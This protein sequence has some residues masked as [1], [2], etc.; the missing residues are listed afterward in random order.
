MHRSVRAALAGLLLPLALDAAAANLLVNPGNEETLVAGEIPGWTEV[1]GTN[2]QQRSSN[3][4]PYEGSFY[5]FAGAGANATLRQT[6][7]LSAFAAAIDGGTL[8][9]Q[10]EGQVRSFDQNPVDTAAIRLTLRD[11][12]SVVL[13]S[14]DSGPVASPDAW[15][16]VAA[17]L[18]V[19]AGSRSIDVDLVSTRAFGTNNDGYFDA[20]SLVAVPVPEPHEWGMLLAGLGILGAWT[21][22]RTRIV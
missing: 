18:P 21:R 1:V 17:R 11:A 16:L 12:A 22:R 9:L 4:T 6:V 7:D 8:A 14:F 10:F 19:P 15:S 13:A 3:P 20:L 2:W 5:F